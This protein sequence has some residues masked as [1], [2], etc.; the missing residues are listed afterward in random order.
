MILETRQGWLILCFGN[1]LPL[2]FGKKEDVIMPKTRLSR[3]TAILIQLQSK[4]VLTAGEIARRFKISLRTAYRDIRALEEAG[5]PIFTEEGKGYSLADGFS[6]PPIMLTE[7]EANALITAERLIVQNKDAS[8]VRNYTDAITKIK[9]VLRYST[10]DKAE[11]L[12]KR[13][14]FISNISRTRT[15]DQLSSIQKSITDYQLLEVEYYSL[16]KQEHST[17]LIEP[18]ALYSTR[19]NWILIAHCRLRHAYREFRLDRIQALRFTETHFEARDFD[20]LKYFI[21]PS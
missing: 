11:L 13:T 7:A 2:F 8:L 20:L 14:A 6:L 4:R 9:S 18:M 10:K 3:L 16:S 17:R 15:S 1:V 19:E 21:P 12:S 5:V